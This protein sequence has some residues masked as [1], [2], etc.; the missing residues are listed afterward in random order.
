M[1]WPT[2]EMIFTHLRLDPQPPPG[3]RAPEAGQDQS[4]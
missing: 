2:I 4:T 1:Q 3:S